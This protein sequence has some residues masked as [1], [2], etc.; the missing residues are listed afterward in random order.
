MSEGVFKKRADEAFKAGNYSEAISCYGEAIKRGEEPKASILS[1]RCACY[2]KKG[3]TFLNNALSDAKETIRAD[4]SWAKGHVRL[5]TVLARKNNKEDAKKAFERALSLEPSNSAAREALAS[6]ESRIPSSSS[7]GFGTGG[8][9]Q[10]PQMPQM[11]MAA[12]V[13]NAWQQLKSWC[14][15]K[16]SKE[17]TS[18]W[19]MVQTGIIVLLLG[20]MW[21]FRGQSQYGGYSDYDYSQT[22]YGGYGGYS[23]GMSWTTWAAVMY[24]AWKLPPHFEAQLGPQYA[25][26]FF[27]MSWT[28]FMW[29]LNMFN[30][31]F[32]K[33]RGGGFG[34]GY[35]GYGGRRRGFF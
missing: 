2:L 14:L 26:P 27:G 34:G 16:L 29:L 24:G 1:N 5:G 35:G 3:G 22:H 32:L 20:Y 18:G 13:T 33:G 21:F 31:N 7:S 17:A 8:M 15:E 6:L 30:N 9:P 11:N 28:T 12:A 19:S 25:R 4:P 23:T 10:M